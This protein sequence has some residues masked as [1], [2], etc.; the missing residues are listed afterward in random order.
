MVLIG[1]K[2][3]QYLNDAMRIY[4]GDDGTIGSMTVRY[5]ESTHA[6]HLNTYKDNVH[7]TGIVFTDTGITYWG[8]SGVYKWRISV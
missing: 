7:L 2:F 5:V 3:G 1:I 4:V 6:L 8:P